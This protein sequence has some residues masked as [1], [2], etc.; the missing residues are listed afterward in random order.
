M[1][2]QVL[3]HQQME[4]RGETFASFVKMITDK[5][6]SFLGSTITIYNSAVPMNTPETK[7]HSQQ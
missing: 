7:T 5:M 3:S 1:G 6:W 2:A 4:K